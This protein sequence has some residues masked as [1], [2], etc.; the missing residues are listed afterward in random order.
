MIGLSNT[1]LADSVATVHEELK[2]LPL[3][4]FDELISKLTNTVV[5]FAI[6]LA[7]AIVVFYVGKFIIN[8]LYS[9][10][11]SVLIRLRIDQS[12]STFVL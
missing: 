9:F 7:I 5:D 11:A 1:E 6:H 10:V 12:L 3:M 8:K 4:S 2:E